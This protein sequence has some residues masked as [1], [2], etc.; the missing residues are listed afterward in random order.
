MARKPSNV[1]PQAVVVTDEHTPGLPAMAE[2]ANVLAARAA[3]V[4][5]QFGDGLP[6]ERNR[7][8]NEARFYMAQSAEAML[9]AG[10]RLIVLK[11]HEPHGDFE[12]IVREQ[13]GLPERT[14]QRMMQASLKY[15]G[16][17]LSA[18]A[19]ALALLG[20]T[21]LFE[22]MTE[23]DEELAALADGGTIAGMDLDD[24]DRMT[25]RELRAALREAHENADAQSRLLSDKNSKIDELAAK[26]NKQ[27]RVKPVA[28]DE[29]GAEIRK[30]T[31][32]IAFE[33]ESII[34]GNLRSAFETLVQ[35]TEAHST[36]HDDFMAGVLGQIQLS[37]N[38]LRSEFDVK[39]VADGEDVPEWLRDP[40]A[41]SSA[42]GA[43][44][45]Q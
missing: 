34:R 44:I 18:K 11:E 26:L 2:A 33:A 40:V 31:S 13:L 3:V 29:A 41:D 12:A 35:H 4:A 10:K 19:P 17:A 45:T 38:Q 5:E 23:D 14:A 39:A 6:Y 24:I 27:K 30:E 22:L 9:E 8:V 43:H 25:S 20:K 7:V 15:M 42:D 1:Q 16:P 21:K 37:L 32:A 28:P 36:P